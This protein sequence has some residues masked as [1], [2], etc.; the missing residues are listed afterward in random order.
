MDISQYYDQEQKTEFVEDITNYHLQDLEKNSVIYTVLKTLCMKNNTGYYSER[1]NF[2]GLNGIYNT[3]TANQHHDLFGFDIDAED[4]RMILYHDQIYMIFNIRNPDTHGRI[5]CISS[6]DEFKPIRLYVDGMTPNHIEK[7]WSPLVKDDQLYF[8]YSY[9]PLVILHYD[10][11]PQGRCDVVFK[12]DN[13][14]LPFNTT[15]Y[16]RGGSNLIPY[17]DGY[18]IGL[19]HSRIATQHRNIG[20]YEYCYYLP[21]IIVLDLHDWSQCRMIHLSKPLMLELPTP[22]PNIKQIEGHRI[23][24]SES[25][26]M[27]AT[28]PNSLIKMDDD[29]CIFTVNVN[30]TITLKYKLY[31]C[32]PQ[33][34]PDH[35]LPIGEWNEIAKNMSLNIIMNASKI[36]KS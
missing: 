29:S 32:T 4:P 17:R 23:I 30:E 2:S 15:T 7:N 34:L 16:I 5:M 22:I 25:P 11:N 14:P 21:H 35:S 10:M 20:G 13:I 9:D 31:P 19:C 1:I 33:H 27:C 18:Y 6:Y 8:V 3:N 24:F 36:H 26:W 12:Q 28:T